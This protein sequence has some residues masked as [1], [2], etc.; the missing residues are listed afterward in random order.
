MKIEEISILLERYQKGIC[1]DEER[2]A[3]EEWIDSL[4]LGEETPISHAELEASLAKIRGN[5]QEVIGPAEASHPAETP[6]TLMRGRSKRLNALMWRRQLAV[7]AALLFVLAGSYWWFYGVRPGGAGQLAFLEKDTLIV[8]D[9]GETRQI[10]LPDGSTIA[11]NAG[12]CFRYPKHF[13]GASRT[14][15]LEKGEASFQVVS[16]P[17]NPF[18]VVTGNLET[19]VLGTSFDIRAY[20]QEDQV[21]IALLT[22]KIKVTEKGR[23]S[24]TLLSP[25]QVIRIDRH[26]DSLTTGIF[27]NE[28]EVAAWKDGALYF[29]DASFGDLAFAI[30]NKYNVTL[31]NRSDRQQWSYTG[32]FR[33]ESLQEVVETICQTEN[34]GYT[35][36]D[37][38]I[39]ITN[40]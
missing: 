10:I 22:G 40:K 39:L 7:A 18:I 38:G 27:D 4:Q 31:I 3:I 1:T 9:K 15:T 8:T 21:Q 20:D 33:N 26:T 19:T 25:H 2:K 16:R 28:Y 17:A 29:K 11:L 35:F 12:T 23:S 30:G 6:V 5:L 34:L 32:L 37:N 36:T 14:V 13:D 24:A